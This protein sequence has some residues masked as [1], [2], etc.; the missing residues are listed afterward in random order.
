MKGRLLDPDQ[1]A[2]EAE[3]ADLNAELPERENA[4]SVAEN[5]QGNY[6]QSEERSG[7]DICE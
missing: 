2:Q 4:E 6:D 1:Q 7:P 3:A 5:P